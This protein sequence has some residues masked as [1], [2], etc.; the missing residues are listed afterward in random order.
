MGNFINS[1]NALSGQL[2]TMTEPR[3]LIWQ[4]HCF[5]RREM[6]LIAAPGYIPQPFWAGN[7]AVLC[8]FYHALPPI[9]RQRL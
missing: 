2:Q 9:Y 8:L 1:L 6:K 5:E 4:G 7:D 3:L